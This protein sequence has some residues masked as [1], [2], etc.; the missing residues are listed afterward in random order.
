MSVAETFNLGLTR[1]RVVLAHEA[2]TVLEAEL[3][4]GGGSAWHMHHRE[5]ETIVVLE[6][7]LV[8]DDGERHELGAGD[9]HVLPRGVR[10]TFVNETEAPV[11]VYFFCAPGGLEQFLR[12]LVSGVSAEEAA[13]RAEIEFG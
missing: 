9:A 1:L 3:D 11:R 4:P 13:A 7:S 5:D 8:V 2:A 12:D 10:H 6:G